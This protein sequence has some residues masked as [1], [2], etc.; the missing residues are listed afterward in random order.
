[1]RASLEHEDLTAMAKEVSK[2]LAPLLKKTE[3]GSGNDTIFNL[4]EI[5]EYIKLPKSWIYRQTSERTIP[6]I[7]AGRYVLFKKSEIDEWLEEKSVNPIPK[8]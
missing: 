7:K 4:K 5:S 1:M 3:Q 8:T 6:F 2:L